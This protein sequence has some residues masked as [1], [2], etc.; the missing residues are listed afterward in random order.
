MVK[1]SINTKMEITLMVCT[2]RTRREGM[3]LITSHKEEFYNL[4]LI[5]SQPKYQK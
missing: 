5:R 3:E 2:S 1:E 4:N